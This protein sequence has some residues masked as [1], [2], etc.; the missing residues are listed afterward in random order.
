MQQG[1]WPFTHRENPAGSFS[2]PA[3]PEPPARFRGQGLRDLL[4]GRPGQYRVQTARSLDLL[5]Q[6]FAAYAE[7]EIRPWRDLKVTFGVRLENQPPATDAEDRLMTFREGTRSLRF[8]DSLPNS[9]FPGDLDPNGGIVPRS[10]I[11]TRGRNFAP[12]IGVAFS[13]RWDARLLRWVLGESGRSVFRASYGV[14]FDHGTFAGSSAA[15]LF[16]A[17]Y[18]PFSTDNRFFLRDPSGAFQAPLAAL[19]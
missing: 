9:L 3:P 13:P 19:P 18:P 17:T 7:T 4:L 8:P 1:T 12:R 14:F 10:T 11:E 16:Q 5:W 2:F 6:E 15:A